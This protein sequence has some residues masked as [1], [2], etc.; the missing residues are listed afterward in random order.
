[1]ASEIELE[2]RNDMNHSPEKSLSIVIPVYNSAAILP[3]LVRQLIAML[4]SIA[5]EHEI[6]LVNDGSRDESWEVIEHLAREYSAVR[7][8][9]MMRNYGQHNALLC[10]IRAATKQIIVTMDDDL[11]HPPEEI[12]KL[13]A[14]L[15]EGYDVVY[16]APQNLPHSWWR[17]LSS[18]IIKKLL[19]W[20][21]GIGTFREVSAFRAFR[22]ELRKSFSGF[23][24]PDVILDVLLC[25]GTT[26]FAA[27]PVRHE[28][29][30]VGSSTYT[31]RTLFNYAALLITGFSTAPLRLASFVGFAFMFL[32]ILVFL[33]VLYVYFFVGSLP[34]FPFLAAIISLFS[35][36][37]L[38]ALGILGEYLAKMFLRSMN[39]PSYVVRGITDQTTQMTE[40]GSAQ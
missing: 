3:E 8:F 34:G 13:L 14:K 22:T 5:I 9:A 28:L 36:A 16:G 23:Q 2:R 25:W 19:I 18:V 7:G 27:A 30:K 38:F 29:R 11:Q 20:A 6:I 1:M 37:Q 33:Y 39:R 17:N 24:S 10:G 40:D 35:G 21:M 12:P 15:D 26:R 4:P 31:M 32:G